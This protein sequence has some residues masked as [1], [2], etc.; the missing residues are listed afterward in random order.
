MAKV[1]EETFGP[2]SADPADKI[3]HAKI[4]E[5]CKR[6]KLQIKRLKGIY[7]SCVANDT[8][9]GSGKI[10]EEN[11]NKFQADPLLLLL[12]PLTQTVNCQRTVRLST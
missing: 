7:R 10:M 8:R 4:K 3:A 12:W 6:V 9:Y 5:G 2:V 11:W 1:D